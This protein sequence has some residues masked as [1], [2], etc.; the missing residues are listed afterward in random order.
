MLTNQKTNRT[1][2]VE[3]DGM[4]VEIL[5]PEGEVKY[6]G[7]MITFVDKE[8]TEVQHRIRCAWPAFA[9]HRQEPTSQFYPL[10]HL[11]HLF[12]AVVTPTVTYGAGTRTTTEEH[13]KVIR[14]TQRRTLRLII[15]TED[16]STHDEPDDEDGTASQ[17]DDFLEWINGR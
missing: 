3:I 1:R 15:Q 6:L 9:R 17:E 8:T 14:T 12:D 2:E 5:A 4:H 7:Q 13:E 11:L 16:D 10:R